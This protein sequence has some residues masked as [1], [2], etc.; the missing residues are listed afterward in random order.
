MVCV[1][2]DSFDCQTSPQFYEI[3][4]AIFN[5]DENSIDREGKNLQRSRPIQ[6]SPIIHLTPLA[7]PP[8]HID[9]AG[10]G[11]ALPIDNLPPNN[12]A[13]SQQNFDRNQAVNVGFA[14]NG[15]FI[16]R[17]DQTTASVQSFTT[18]SVTPSTITT[19]TTTAPTTIA[20]SQRNNSPRENQKA[21]KA[22]KNNTNRNFKINPRGPSPFL[23]TT[24]PKLLQS[25]K[26]GA[27]QD[28]LGALKQ[29]LPSRTPNRQLIKATERN[30]SFNQ[31]FL[32]SPLPTSISTTAKPQIPS[33]TRSRTSTTLKPFTKRQRHPTTTRRPTTS[34]P[35]S[36]TVKTTTKSRQSTLNVNSNLRGFSQARVN[37]SKFKTK[38][39]N[40]RLIP[41]QTNLIAPKQTFVNPIRNSTPGRPLP[42]FEDNSFS[43]PASPRGK[44]IIGSEKLSSKDKKLSNKEKNKR[45]KNQLT[46]LDVLHD[47]IKN[48]TII[49]SQALIDNEI[50]GGN[51]VKRKVDNKP[52]KIIPKEIATE[53]T[54]DDSMPRKPLRSYISSRGV[55]R[56]VYAPLHANGV[57]NRAKNSERNIKKYEDNNNK[58]NPK[59]WK[60]SKNQKLTPATIQPAKQQ[61]KLLVENEQTSHK[62]QKIK[63][64][65][66][67]NSSNAEDNL[68]VS[69]NSA[70]NFKKSKNLNKRDQIAIVP[71]R[72]TSNSQSKDGRSN[73]S[74]NYSHLR[75]QR[76]NARKTISA[77][78][79]SI[80]EK[81]K[82]KWKDFSYSFQNDENA[83]KRIMNKPAHFSTI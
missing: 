78:P 11:R 12:Q 2:W 59:K 3:N 77:Y 52:F 55:Q 39:Q 8:E 69:N 81:R 48:I 42:L 40:Q 38:T 47:L 32:T 50:N 5:E 49:Q 28:F 34:V 29:I 74:N 57:S 60:L 53:S 56:Y 10:E 1:W 14:N 67:I 26:Q 25:A 65:N 27:N 36:Q 72:I 24:K 83:L 70:K 80:R 62:K 20:T 17:H 16:I 6:Q 21:G 41:P 43:R 75:S 4:R 31:A 76:K 15:R 61:S 35:K 73:K 71:T 66:C 19:P 22:I 68:C 82:T 13:I 9:V 79:W 46:A 54:V 64:R 45:Q 58:N 44:S 63:L 18:T 33:L 51:N 37:D 30:S 7:P 23:T